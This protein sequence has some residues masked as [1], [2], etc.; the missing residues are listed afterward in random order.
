MT[1]VG[2]PTA[3]EPAVDT[4]V[5]VT[6]DSLGAGS[7]TGAEAS[8]TLRRKGFR[9]MRQ[10]PAGL[11]PRRQRTAYLY[12]LPALIVFVVFLG[13]PLVQT[14]QYS[15]YHWNGLGQAT[16]AG[17]SNYLEVFRNADLRAGFGHA[18]QLMIFYSLIPVCLGLILATVVS[19]SASSRSMSFYRTVFFLP[20][21]IATVVVA[22]MWISI[23]SQ[24]GMLNQ[25]LR[26]VGLGDLARVWLGDPTSALICIGVVGSWFNTGLCVVLFLSGIGTIAPEI[27]EAARIDGASR[28][29]EFFWITLPAVRGQIAVALTLTMVSALKTFDLV[30]ITTRGGP[31]TSTTV[32]AFE[33][34]NQAFNTGKVGLAAA[35]AVVLTVAIVLVTVLISRIA[36]KDVQ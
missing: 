16:V 12:I 29:R 30:Y 9:L 11:R 18:A 27:Y 2:Y 28:R 7:N 13:I 33:A 19:R 35:I 14:I 24:N 4:Q 17:L 23:Y 32:P 3:R 6:T 21:V 22:T 31:G 34:Y 10:T 26:A 25:L 15:F 36:P 1:G 8:A 20:Q 5:H